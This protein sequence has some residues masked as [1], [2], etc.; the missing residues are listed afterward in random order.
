MDA[1]IP[2][3]GLFE[4][5]S[6]FSAPSTATTETTLLDAVG[7]SKMTPA[8]LWIPASV[9]TL[10]VVIP[11]VAWTAYKTILTRCRAAS[12]TAPSPV[13]PTPLIASIRV[14]AVTEI[15]AKF[16]EDKT[17]R[18]VRVFW[19]PISPGPPELHVEYKNL[20]VAIGTAVDPTTT[21]LP[22]LARD[23]SGFFYDS[24][25]SPATPS[26]GMTE[27]TLKSPPSV[28]LD[29]SAAA[30]EA[31]STDEA[32]HHGRFSTILVVNEGAVCTPPSTPK[33]ARTM[34]TLT[35]ASNSL[36][37]H[38]LE[39][40]TKA[41]RRQVTTS[42]QIPVIRIIGATPERAEKKPQRYAQR[43]NSRAITPR[44]VRLQN[45]I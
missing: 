24:D 34:C 5:H 13:S 10:A 39:A 33:S 21:R 8:A 6:T 23:A 27:Y 18:S 43:F 14:V 1:L 40:P 29:A 2:L 28:D 45:M 3:G 11:L 17:M 26:A 25:H 19:S 12:L 22:L 15:P 44:Q 38:S 4:T 41:I 35:S 30:H 36:S 20:D 37:L 32:V 9:I 31:E 16:E 7:V 42:E